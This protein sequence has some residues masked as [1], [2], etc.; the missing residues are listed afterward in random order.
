MQDRSH[1]RG[2]TSRRWR[3]LRTSLVGLA[4]LLCDNTILVNYVILSATDIYALLFCAL[5]VSA[6]TRERQNLVETHSADVDDANFERR[7]AR[8]GD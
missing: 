2:A 4:A 3:I 5:A 8:Q 1:E 6:M 7:R